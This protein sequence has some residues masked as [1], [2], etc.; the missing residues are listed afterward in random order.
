MEISNKDIH[1]LRTMSYFVEATHNIIETEGID[2]VTVRKVSKQAGYNPATLYNYFENLDYL[3]GF[4]S[5]K[6]LQDYH[7]SLKQEVEPLKDP[8]QRF[9]AI[10]EKFCHYS[11]EKP[12]IYRALFFKSPRF[13]LCEIFDF[14][15]K[16]FPDE[17]GEHTIDIQRMMKGCTLF[18]RNLFVLQDVVQSKRM[19]LRPEELQQL[20]EMMIILY[21]GKLSACIEDEWSQEEK[22]RG[23]KDTVG[24]MEALLDLYK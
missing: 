18:S 17:L 20:N 16:M 7:K 14:Y 19:R 21:R 15:F 10:W 4:A 1:R 8:K 3:V 23:V 6:Y 13:S 12:K 9:L 22:V 11:F 5:I 24:Y 2:A